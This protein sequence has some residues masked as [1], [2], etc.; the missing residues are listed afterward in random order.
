MSAVF[1][2]WYDSTV[3]TTGR[4]S[5]QFLVLEHCGAYT[6]MWGRSTWTN[7]VCSFLHL[8]P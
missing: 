4:L 1:R 2:F 6:F 5:S 8:F 3:Q 7:D